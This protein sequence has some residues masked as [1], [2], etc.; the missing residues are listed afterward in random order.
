MAGIKLKHIHFMAE[1]YLIAPLFVF[2]AGWLDYGFALLMVLMLG[3][4]CYKLWT[5]NANVNSEVFNLNMLMIAIGLAMV[6]CFFAGVGYFYY[7]SWDYHFRNA[8]FRDLINYE[9]P[10]MYDRAHTPMAY[11]MGFWLIPAMLTKFTGLFLGNARQLFLVGNVYLFIYAVMGTVL[12]FLELAAALKIKSAKGLLGACLIFMFFSGLDVIGFLFFRGTEQPFELHL[13][14]WASVMQYSSLSTSMF[15]VYNQLICVAL[16]VFWVYNKRDIKSF[17]LMV[18]VM[19]FLTPYPTASIGVYMVVLAISQF[20][21]QENKQAFI[22]TQVFSVPNLIGVFW[23]LPVVIL[24]LITNSG[25]ID[26]LWYVFDF[27]SPERLLLF[28][29]LEFLLYVGVVFKYFKKDVFFITTVAL[30]IL[31]PF[32]RLDRQ[33]NFCM[34]AAIPALVMLAFFVIRFLFE[35]IKLPQKRLACTTVILLLIF[36]AATPC[37]EFYRGLYYVHKTGKIALVQDEIYTLNQAYVRM[38]VFGWSANHQFSANNYKKDIFWQ[39]LA[40][41]RD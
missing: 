15:W 12:V 10:V 29:V 40:K 28:M 4:A 13:D 38:P 31:I 21:S 3:L 24:Y 41:K 23:V 16:M 11:Y 17:G 32:V 8:V 18:P 22:S 39:Y 34:R 7:Q 30:L 26:K 14:W 33:N 9:W 1:A 2:F 36:G 20:I 6:W 35:N 27:I 25:G 37:M 5:T 19:L